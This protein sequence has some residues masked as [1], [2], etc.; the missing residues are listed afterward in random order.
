[1]LDGAVAPVEWDGLAELQRTLRSLEGG[2]LPAGTMPAVG[3]GVR[4]RMARRML[5][6]A[7]RT[8][9]AEQERQRRAA[10]HRALAEIALR[11]V[12]RAAACPEKLGP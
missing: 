3:R 12:P 6:D 1:M 7:L 8:E 11:A 2:E 10:F 9:A 5:E 4:L